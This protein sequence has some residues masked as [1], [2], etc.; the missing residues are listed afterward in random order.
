MDDAEQGSAVCQ[1][2]A[3][4]RKLLHHPLVWGGQDIVALVLRPRMADD[5]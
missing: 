3:E 2:C 4:L 1:L 5:S